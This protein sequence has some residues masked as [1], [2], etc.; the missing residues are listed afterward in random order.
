[1]IMHRTIWR[2]DLFSLFVS[3]IHLSFPLNVF[4]T[5]YGNR[6]SGPIPA[7]LGDM[8]TLQQL[9][10]EANQFSGEIPPHIGNLSNLQRLVLSS[11]NFTGELPQTLAKLTNMTDFRISGTGL[12]GQL[13]DFIVSWTQLERLEIQ[14]TNLV[15]PIPAGISKLENL[16][17]L[18]LRNCLLFGQ[19]PDYIGQFK[20]LRILDLSFNNLTGGIP[21]SLQ[22]LSRLQFVYVNPFQVITFM[23]SFLRINII[24]SN[25]NMIKWCMIFYFLVQTYYTSLFEEKLSLQCS[26]TKTDVYTVSTNS[27]LSMSNPELYRTARISPLSLKYYGLCLWN[28]PYTVKLYFSEIVITDDKNYTSLGRRIFDVRKIWLS[29]FL[30]NSFGT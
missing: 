26:K 12:S 13:P 16:E 10:L 5:L 21:N 29:I 19:I 6:L 9:T 24:V 17:Q 2:V 8:V 14:G 30:A 1:M 22:F 23:D 18:I 27:T 20:A 4:R 11:N 3:I 25:I 28:G 7:Q 15:G